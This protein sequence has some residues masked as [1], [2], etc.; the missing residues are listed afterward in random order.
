MFC[1][2]CGY[3][4]ALPLPEQKTGTK[5]KFQADSKFSFEQLFSFGYGPTVNMLRGLEKRIGHDELIDMLKADSEKRGALNGRQMAK[6][7]PKNDL[8]AFSLIM[9]K[10]D[11][12]W[13]HVLTFDIIEDTLTVFEIKVRECLWAKTFRKFKA[14]DF[15]YTLIC[16]GDF[17][18]AG[19]FNPRMKMHRSKTLMQGQDYCNHRWVMKA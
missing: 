5:P 13:K 10:P 18:M 9:K 7:F 11:Y 12:F 3:L 16:H 19:G 17:S 8:A 1:L 4:G 6:S 2:G 15:G 14:G